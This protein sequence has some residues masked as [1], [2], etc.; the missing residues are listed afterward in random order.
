MLYEHTTNISGMLWLMCWER[1]PTRYEMKKN[2]CFNGN[3]LVVCACRSVL[4]VFDRRT[5]NIPV[6]ITN[7]LSFGVNH[8]V[9][10]NQ[11]SLK[12]LLRAFMDIYTS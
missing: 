8:S 12:P 9:F 10:F 2:T 5:V 3:Y 11:P 4:P 7:V 6:V 1:K